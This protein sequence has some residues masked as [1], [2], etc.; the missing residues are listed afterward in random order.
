[1]TSDAVELPRP[2]PG[3]KLLRTSASIAASWRV[4][5]A[6]R[7]QNLSEVKRSYDADDNH[8]GNIIWSRCE[9]RTGGH[10][11]SGEELLVLR[12]F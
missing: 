3:V 4:W 2:N 1:M 10:P 11:G 7:D 6:L 9:G 5:H 12:L 8:F